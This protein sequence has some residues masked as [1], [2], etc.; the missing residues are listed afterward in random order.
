MDETGIIIDQNAINRIIK[1]LDGIF[2]ATEPRENTPITKALFESGLL[3]ETNIKKSPLMPVV[4][5]RLRSSFHS[6]TRNSEN[7]QYSDK[8]NK[9]FNGSLKE[10]IKENQEIAVGSNVEYAPK[11]NYLKGFLSQ[12]FYATLPQIKRKLHDAFTVVAKGGN[13]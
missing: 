2:K 10:V 12:A 13:I 8:N 6:K 1:H 9:S 5:G 7:Y 3:L 11:Q 4:T